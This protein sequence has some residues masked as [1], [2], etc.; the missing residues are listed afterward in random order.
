[1]QKNLGKIWEAKKMSKKVA[2]VSDSTSGLPDEMAKE[3]GIFTSYLMI[4]FGDE[5]YQEFKEITPEK[6]IEMCRAQSE[7]PTTSQPSIGLT[8]ELY[9]KILAEGYDEIIHITIS[10]GLSGSYQ[11]A[12]SA[13]EMVNATKIHVVD[14]G[15]VA[16]P[17]GALAIKAAELANELS[18][19]K[20]ILAYLENMKKDVG[21]YAAIYT[22]TNLK[23]G[24][25]LSPAEAS[26]GSLLQIKPILKLNK[27][28][29]QIEAAG[30]VRTFKKAIAQLIK[31]AKE[32]G[33]TEEYEI[34]LLHIKNEEGLAELRSEI[35]KIYPNNQIHEM[36]LSL[37]VSTHAGEGALAITWAKTK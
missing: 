6:F 17:Q 20:E 37:V 25:R 34:G 27:E 26:L 14:S 22:L 5:S 10:S 19:T 16:Y 31:T 8:V 7:L 9:E 24:G 23:K 13:A 12:V 35:K 28:S 32:A 33:L 21:L 36:P 2:I 4:I 29:G 18:D 3:H 1:M 11:S 15:T 30:K